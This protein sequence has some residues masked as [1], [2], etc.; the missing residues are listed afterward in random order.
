MPSW[1]IVFKTDQIII[2]NLK[3]AKKK[4]KLI[5]AQKKSLASIPL[6]LVYAASLQC[7]SNSY[8]VILKPI[9]SEKWQ[10]YRFLKQNIFTIS[11]RLYLLNCMWSMY[12]SFD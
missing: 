9:F 3:K 12:K 11:I 8:E 4:K 5:Q 1:L 7:I 2:M 10:I 6:I